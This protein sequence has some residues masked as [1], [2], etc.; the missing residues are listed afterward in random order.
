MT[1]WFRDYLYL[2]LGGNKGNLLFKIR[3]VAIVFLVSGFWHGA[4]W[5]FLFWGFVNALFF[6]PLVILKKNTLKIETFKKETILPSFKEVFQAKYF[7]S[8]FKNSQI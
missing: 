1:S 7:A 6:I 5:T 4:N 8:P 3:N 2:P